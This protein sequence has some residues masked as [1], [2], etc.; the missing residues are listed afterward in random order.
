MSYL[1][2]SPYVFYHELCL[3]KLVES[4]SAKPCLAAGCVVHVF[5][6]CLIVRSRTMFL[7]A[8]Q[9]QLACVT[10]NA[11]DRAWRYPSH[12]PEDICVLKAVVPPADYTGSAKLLLS[13]FAMLY[14]KRCVADRPLA[15]QHHHAQPGRVFEFPHGWR[16][17]GV[18]V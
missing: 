16:L 5:R 8:L 1:S 3:E 2:N 6:V 14:A 18:D 11:A 12:S 15:H 13:R 17:L 7:I 9:F 4:W 10:Q